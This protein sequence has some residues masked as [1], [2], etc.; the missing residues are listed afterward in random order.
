MKKKTPDEYSINQRRVFLSQISKYINIKR[1]AGCFRSIWR[2]W[3]HWS[4]SVLAR[5][6]VANLEGCQILEDQCVCM[7]QHVNVR[8][9][10]GNL[11]IKRI[12]KMRCYIEQFRNEVGQ[13][14]KKRQEE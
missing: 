3:P 14:E 4:G 9:R 5:T 2:S 12:N 11:M 10:E 1:T 6:G 13:G 7:G 8:E